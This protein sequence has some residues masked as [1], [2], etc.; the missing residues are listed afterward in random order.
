VTG[1]AEGVLAAA[2]LLGDARAKWMASA[3]PTAIIAGDP[4]PEAPEIET[5]RR[6]LRGINPLHRLTSKP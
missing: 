2:A 4:L 3:V 1:L 6:R 5:A